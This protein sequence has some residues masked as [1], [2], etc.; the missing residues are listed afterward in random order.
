MSGRVVGKFVTVCGVRE[1]FA[2]AVWCVCVCV[3]K[4]RRTRTRR[5]GKT[6]K[7]DEEEEGKVFGSV[8]CA[9]DFGR[10]VHGCA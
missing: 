4:K 1:W 2:F 8:C 10:C 5:T 9:H 3:K 7:R 6:G